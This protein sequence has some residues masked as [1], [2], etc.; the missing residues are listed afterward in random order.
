MSLLGI[1]KVALAINKMDLTGFAKDRFESIAQEFLAFS[2]R[3]G[4]EDV[5]A[6]PLSALR[7]DNVIAPSANMHW[8]RGPTLIEHLETVD[9]TSA[10][11]DKGFRMPVQWVNR[12]NQDFR[13]YA[14]TIASGEIRPGD[15]ISILPS[16]LSSTVDRIVT[17]DKD[18]DK[19]IVGQSMTLTLTDEVDCSRGDLMVAA[20]APAEVNDRLGATLVWMAAEA[21]VPGRAYWLKIGTQTVTASVARVDEVIDVNTMERQ[22]GQPLELNDIGRCEILLDRKVAAQT[23]ADNRHLGGF[24]LIDR[25]TNAT[26]AAGMVDSFPEAADTAAGDHAAGR[27]IWL[28]GSTE[29]KIAVAQKA[30]QRLGARGRPTFVLDDVS[31][32]EGLNADLGGAPADESEHKRRAREVARLMSRAGVTVL[33]A[34][35]ASHEAAELGSD[36]HVADASDD[37]AD[38][39][40]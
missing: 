8:H 25:A 36:V 29:E 11:V 14:G 17:F 2:R 20:S 30:Q 31:L 39:I 7:G 32:R 9:V 6:I 21:M 40:I 37:W 22:P 33:V 19:A 35:D 13:G 26:V 12:A 24:I 23:Y 3:L 10:G 28:T 15:H 38:W 16:G 34:L 1:R 18:L 5:V 4:F 27:I